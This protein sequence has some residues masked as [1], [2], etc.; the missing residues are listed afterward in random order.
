VDDRACLS[1][2]IFVLQSGIP[3]EMLPPEMGCG[4]GMTCWRRLQDWQRRGVWKKLRHALLQRVGPEEGIDGEHCGVD[5]QTVRAVFWGDLPAKTPR[6][7]AKKAPSGTGSS[8]AEAGRVVG[9]GTQL[10]RM[11]LPVV[12]PCRGVGLG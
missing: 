9:C 8:V 12:R 5:S 3:W 2:I 1:G 4:S 10:P 11:E 7:A 6:I